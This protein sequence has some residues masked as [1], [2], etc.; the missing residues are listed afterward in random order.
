[1]PGPRD[2]LDLAE[3]HL[4]KVLAAWDEPTDWLDLTLYGF[5]CIENAVMAAALHLDV[6]VARSHPSKIAA[7]RVLHESH[8]L[9]EVAPLLE[10][11]NQARKAVAYGD[12][13]LPD[14]DA[15]DASRAVEEY[16]IAVRDLLSGGAG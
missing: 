11:L 4:E 2:H 1:M 16:V 6:R 12:V 14:M 15:E 3:K 10:R 7:A 5:Y 13:D 8:R 9:P